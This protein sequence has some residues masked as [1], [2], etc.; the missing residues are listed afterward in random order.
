MHTQV[1]NSV[2]IVAL[3]EKVLHA[4]NV[5]STEDLLEESEVFN[6]LV[7]LQVGGCVVCAIQ[8]TFDRGL[9]FMRSSLA[10]VVQ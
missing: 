7:A 10:I 1:K 5:T 3:E 9:I 8:S 2:E 6:M 4:I